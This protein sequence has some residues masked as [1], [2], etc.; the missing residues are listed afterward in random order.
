VAIYFTG[1]NEQVFDK[2]MDPETLLKS[3]PDYYAPRFESIKEMREEDDG[4]GHRGQEFR[5]VASFVNV[6][7]F[8]AAKLTNP[9]FL[10]DKKQFYRFI[11][12]YPEYVSYQRR[13]GG[14]GTAKDDLKLPLKALGL[15]YPGGPDDAQGWD[16]VDVPLDPASEIAGGPTTETSEANA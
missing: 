12:K 10:K 6:P 2:L 4:T 5:R 11:D 3:A 9:D 7:L 13:N 8:L 14:R 16:A 1:K 15:D